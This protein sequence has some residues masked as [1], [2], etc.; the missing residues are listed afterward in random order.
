MT[1]L[2]GARERMVQ[3]QIAARGIRDPAVLEAMR[4]V[5]REAFLPPELAEFAY[6]DHPLP[7]AQ[8]QTIS[9][10]FIVAL[11]TAARAQAPRSGARDRHRVGLRRRDP[12]A[13]R[14]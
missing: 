3:T 10:P 7:I 12:R 2:C 11:M 14:A 9:Q 6:E 1:D 4:T 8:G 13:H 5:P